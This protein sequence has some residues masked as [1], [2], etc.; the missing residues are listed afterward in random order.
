MFNYIEIEQGEEIFTIKIGRNAKENDLLI[1]E[2]DS[3][4]TW[5]HLENISGPHIVVN[6]SGK[7]IDKTNLRYIGSLFTT[8][9]NGLQNNYTVIYTEIK[10]VQ[11]TKTP[12]LVVCKSTKTLKY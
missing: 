12:G 9:K 6:N 1:R 7:K 11:L 10:N 2:S 3:D 5:F 8:Y 4:D